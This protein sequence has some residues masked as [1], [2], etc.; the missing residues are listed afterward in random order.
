MKWSASFYGNI[1]QLTSNRWRC[2]NQQF[3]H[4]INFYLWHLCDSSVV[5]LILSFAIFVG[6]HRKFFENLSVLLRIVEFCWFLNTILWENCSIL[7][8]LCH[9]N[10]LCQAERGCRTTFFKINRHFSTQ[11]FPKVFQVIDFP[12]SSCV[13]L[14]YESQ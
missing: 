4:V 10:R 12:V 11:F 6:I 3:V 2:Y 9:K 7:S 5:L 14:Q 1:Q 13:Q 8:V